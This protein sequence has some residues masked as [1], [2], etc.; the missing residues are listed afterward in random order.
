MGPEESRLCP[1]GSCPGGGQSPGE[2]RV[3]PLEGEQPPPL[4]MG[5][6]LPPTQV[7]HPRPPASSGSARASPEQEPPLPLSVSALEQCD[8][9]VRLGVHLALQSSRL[10]DEGLG[11]IFGS[12]CPV[13]AGGQGLLQGTQRSFRSLMGT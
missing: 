4:G 11:L 1:G 7:A 9:P 10:Q 13:A 2:C 6:P 5:R 3:G 8:T 12:L